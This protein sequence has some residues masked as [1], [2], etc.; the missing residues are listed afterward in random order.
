MRARQSTAIGFARQSPSPSTGGRESRRALIEPDPGLAG[1]QGRRADRR[2]GTPA[3]DMSGPIGAHGL[4]G[5]KPTLSSPVGARPARAH[6]LAASS[7]ACQTRLAKGLTKRAGQAWRRASRAR[8]G[9][10]AGQTDA[11]RRPVDF[12]ASLGLIQFCSSNAQR[13]QSGRLASAARPPAGAQS[14]RSRDCRRL[15]AALA[16]LA[17]PVRA[18]CRPR[19]ARPAPLRAHVSA[20]T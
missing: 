3:D 16:G 6:S 19:P 15:R 9:W 4:G 10:P 12:A 11:R 18:R 8:A 5:C 17:K 7:L 1:R 2:P 20:H 13:A 14:R